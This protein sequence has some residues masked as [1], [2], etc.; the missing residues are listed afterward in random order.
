MA[1][2][3]YLA[4]MFS[5]TLFYRHAYRMRDA[6]QLNTEEVHHTYLKM[7]IYLIQCYTACFSVL[8][9]IAAMFTPWPWLALAAG[10]V[11]FLIGPQVWLLRRRINRRK[12]AESISDT[13]DTYASAAEK[14]T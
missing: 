9:A 5:F 14:V 6:L 3:G 1:S 13:A 7:N 2:T 10:F 11:Y 4:L 8:I 12:P